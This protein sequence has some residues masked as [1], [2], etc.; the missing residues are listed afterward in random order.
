MREIGSLNRFL[1]NNQ[2]G[3]RSPSLSSADYCKLNKKHRS[4][5]MVGVVYGISR[6]IT[7]FRCDSLCMVML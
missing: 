5:R 4:G 3:V 6:Y 7:L 2:L 1:N